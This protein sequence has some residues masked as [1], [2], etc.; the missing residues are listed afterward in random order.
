MHKRGFF[1]LLMMFLLAVPAARAAAN[2]EP[3]PEGLAVHISVKSPLELLSGI[4]AYAAA[5]TKGTDH[6]IP[7]G[8]TAMLA[9]MWHPVLFNSLELDS[10]THV[11]LPASAMPEDI[12]DFPES[13]EY[14]DAFFVFGAPNFGD[15]V[16]LLEEQGAVE[17][18]EDAAG[19]NAAWSVSFTMGKEW[20]LVDLGNGRAAFGGDIEVVRNALDGW[21]PAH[22]S[23]AA[24]TVRFAPANMRG[25]LSGAIMDSLEEEKDGIIRIISE[26]GFKSDAVKGL[27]GVLEKFIPQFVGEFD[28]MP[29]AA[30]DMRF[31]RDEM[32]ISLKA[33]PA[34]AS[35]LSE[36]AAQIGR[37]EQLDAA[38][39][40]QL[41]A[42]AASLFVAAPFTD[43]LPDAKNRLALFAS[44]VYGG[45]L[46]G[47]G[48]KLAAVTGD[49]MDSVPGRTAAGNYFDSMKQYSLALYETADPEKAMKAFTDG[50]QAFNDFWAA[51]IDDP[52]CGLAIEGSALTEGG[53]SYRAYDVVFAN[54]EHVRKAFDSAFDDMRFFIAPVEGGIVCAS[55]ELTGAE[56]LDRLAKIK[57]PSGQ[58]LFASAR[59]KEIMAALPD[60][61]AGVGVLDASGYF[62]MFAAQ[63]TR[64]T[65]MPDGVRAAAASFITDREKNGE[66][67]GFAL[68]ADDGLLTG[69]CIVPAAAVN[70]VIRDSAAFKK[71][72]RDAFTET[73]REELNIP[74]PG[75]DGYGGD[76]EE[77]ADPDAE[78]E[79]EEPNGDAP[80]AA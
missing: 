16:A 39:A 61:R 27:V 60:S 47:F 4:D 7:P 21:T 63:F 79:E 34:E 54:P 37:A 18:M 1:C 2:P 20:T 77:D 26:K 9:Q 23:D 55:G 38:F 42:G 35:I 17:R 50:F 53:T 75:Q 59:A 44:F 13:F 68:S 8:L 49:F 28:S 70:Q 22:E 32:R 12:G 10:E 31:D 45:I 48:E 15:L 78:A 58:S 51:A 19:F 72:I 56:F 5:A 36:L 52:D 74:D 41:P 40:E 43:M 71:T 14:L 69:G 25:N 30:L 65:D 46:P 64:L 29:I 66:L 24:L 67:I 76:P 6:E 57:S 33:E 3:L 62:D 11:I 80:A 73:M